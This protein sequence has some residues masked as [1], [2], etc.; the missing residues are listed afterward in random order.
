MNKFP[1]AYKAGGRGSQ[2]E[3]GWRQGDSDA[4]KQGERA[5]FKSVKSQCA[6][7]IFIFD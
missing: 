4:G 1:A 6:I 5:L 2:G 3:R 7:L